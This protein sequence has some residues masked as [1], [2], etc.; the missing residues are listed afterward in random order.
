MAKDI[1][2]KTETSQEPNEVNTQEGTD[3]EKSKTVVYTQQQ[4]DSAVGKAKATIEGKWRESDRKAQA[5]ES[6]LTETADRLSDLEDKLARAERDRDE[7]LFAGMEDEPSTQRLKVLYGQVAKTQDD[8]RKRERELNKV[9][10]EAFDGL[11]F[12]DATNTSKEIKKNY[13]I[14][15]DPEELMTC[16]SWEDMQIMAKDLVIKGLST[17]EPEK[18][19]ETESRLPKHIDSGTQ[20]ASGTG[21]VFKG[22]EIQ[23]MT[24]KERFD[25][26]SEISKATQEGRVKM[27]E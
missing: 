3:E 7:R 22:S 4:L 27:N 18:T 17:K 8:L 11:K 16:K 24:P 26:H 23:N 1:L 15:V 5:A 14:E 10:A 19:K 6:R 25:L 20:V 13:G 21:R 9:Q 2:E 12:R